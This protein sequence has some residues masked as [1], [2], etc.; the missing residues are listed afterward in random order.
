VADHA[1]LG[2]YIGTRTSLREQAIV[3]LVE[4]N[5]FFFTT[6]LLGYDLVFA[7]IHAA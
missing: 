4:S 2:G 1:V 5:R 6:S 3:S 7:V